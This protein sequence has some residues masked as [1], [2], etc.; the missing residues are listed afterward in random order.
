MTVI[1][2]LAALAL[3]AVGAHDAYREAKGESGL[4]L[5]KPRIFV[6]VV[7]GLLLVMFTLLMIV[8]LKA[9]RA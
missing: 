7:V 9:V 6:F 5:L 3:W 8:G 4:V 1:F 2:A